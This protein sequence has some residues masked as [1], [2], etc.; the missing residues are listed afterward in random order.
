MDAAKDQTL[1]KVALPKDWAWVDGTQVLSDFGEHTYKANYTPTGADADLYNAKEN[2]DVTVNVKWMLVDP[3]QTAVNI[4]IIIITGDD[5]QEY[6]EN[7]SVK[8]E[9]KA[10]VKA[11]AKSADYVITLGDNEKLAAVYGVKLFRTVDGVEQEIQPSDIKEGATIQAKIEIPDDAKGKPFKVL[12]IHSADDIS[13]VAYTVSADGSYAIVE[14]DKLSDFAFV[15][16]G[17]PVSHGF[18]RVRVGAAGDRGER[19]PR[20]GR[21]AR[22]PPDLRRLCSPCDRAGAAVGAAHAGGFAPPVRHIPVPDHAGRR[23]PAGHAAGGGGDVLLQTAAGVHQDAGVDYPR[24]PADDPA[25]DHLL[26]PRTGF[27]HASVGQR[28]KRPP[29]CRLGGLHH[30]LRL[31]FLRNFPRRYPVDPCGAGRSRPGPG[32]E[33]DPDLFPG[34]APSGHQSHPS[35]D[36]Q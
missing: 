18:C 10:E 33:T 30:Q 27:Q 32:H 17:D 22:Q 21:G 3:T 9:V 34:Q 23:A 31:L 24:I 7:I 19:P 14:T 1:S 29:G 8:I 36:I 12:H 16:E 2:V 15:V 20:P 13:E 35:A 5:T 11:E 4:T 26:L 25:A 28:R 6:E